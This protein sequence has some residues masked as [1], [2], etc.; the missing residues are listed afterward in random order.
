MNRE[1]YTD[2]ESLICF[3]LFKGFIFKILNLF[4]YFIY[5]ISVKN[6]NYYIFKLKCK[7]LITVKVLLKIFLFTNKN[8]NFNELI[9]IVFKKFILEEIK[10]NIFKKLV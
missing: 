9:Y 3:L 5:V 1:K 4:L 8:K 2:L 7:F 10:S 6:L